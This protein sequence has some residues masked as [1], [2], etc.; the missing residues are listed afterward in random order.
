MRACADTRF[1]SSAWSTWIGLLLAFIAP[2]D[3]GATSDG[4]SV[5]ILQPAVGQPL[6]DLVTVSLHLQGTAE[7]DRVEIQVD[8]QLAGTLRQPPWQLE[9]DVGSENRE[10]HIAVQA[11]GR[12]GEVARSHLV[13]PAVEVHE[14]MDLDLQQLYLTVTNRRRERVVDVDR[15]ALT[16]RDDGRRQEIVTWAGGEIPFTAVLL[17]DASN[18]M[19]G[20][21]LQAALRGARR[22]VSGMQTHDEARVL[23]TSDRVLKS[24]PWGGPLNETDAATFASSL[25]P[26]QAE[27]GSAILD[28]LYMALELLE[29]RQGRRVLILLSDG[30]DQHSHLTAQ[31][32]QEVARQSQA[33]IY[34]VRLGGGDAS[35][36]GR[37]QIAWTSG[38]SHQ[39]Q[40]L[41][42]PLSA[43]RDKEMKNTIQRTLEE[44]VQRSGGRILPVTT[45][46][47]IEP[48]FAD[49]LQELR[50]QIAIGY[51]PEPRRDDGSWRPV[52]IRLKGHGLSVRTR[53]GYVDR[54]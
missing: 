30:H 2:V 37:S 16:L 17:V 14:A 26:Q 42:Y 4:L 6:F 34:W 22:F 23:V 20:G 31:Q 8:G 51:Y 49:I 13:S 54:P 21:P 25:Q 44:A 28:H 9:V 46:R 40:M 1:R 24:S 12:H 15:A 10:R 19:T 47:G 38:S 27:G 52:K 43:W 29:S 33:M 7:I 45:W 32:V 5:E 41:R 50:Q 36:N 53:Q 35:V 18:S 39:V 11:F 48:A 3:L